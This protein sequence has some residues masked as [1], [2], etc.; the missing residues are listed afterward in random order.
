MTKIRVAFIGCGGISAK[1]TRRM[2]DMAEVEI[3]GGHDLTKEIV[4]GLWK[5]TWEKGDPPAELPPAFTDLA[6]MYRQTKPNAVVICTPHTLHFEQAMQALDAGCHVL[7]EKPMVTNADHAHT[8]A[9][10][11]EQTGLILAVAYN[12]PCTPEFGYLRQLIRDKTLG[13][14]ELVSGWLVQDWLKPTAGSWRQKPELAG[15][16]QAY[17]SGAHLLNSVCWSV[18]SDIAEVHA[19]VDNLGAPVDINSSINIRFASGAFASI[20]IGGNCSDGGAHLTY[21]FEKGRV[22]IDGWGGDWIKIYKDGR[23]VKYPPIT[24]G[25]NGPTENFVDAVLGR[26]EPLTTPANG[27]VQS[28]LMDAIYASAASGKPAKPK[29]SV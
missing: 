20:V 25:A 17:D 11:V 16:G 19:F 7:M 18:E 6:E 5:R 22:D 24:S 3:V 4:N 21:A 29:S 15:G 13:K 10:K 23:Q 2:K 26:A 28:E 14:L 8:V 12:T 9:K 27:I 1:H